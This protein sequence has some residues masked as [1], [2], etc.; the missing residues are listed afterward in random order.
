MSRISR[1]SAQTRP[2]RAEA[3]SEAARVASARAP[4]SDALRQSPHRSDRFEGTGR[5]F[6]P[7][8]IASTPKEIPS[9][10]QLVLREE[11]PIDVPSASGVVTLSKSRFIIVDDDM[12]IFHQKKEGADLLKSSKKHDML[13]DLEGLCRTPDGNGVFVLSEK[14]G[15]VYRLDFEG[16]GKDLD[17][18]KPVKQ[19]RLPK[20]SKKD[21]NKGWEGIDLLPGHFFDDGKARMVAVHEG[22]PK[23]VGVFALPDLK[24]GVIL[25]LPDDVADE[26]RDLSDIAVDPATGH[27]FVLSDESETIV[28]MRLVTERKSA[29]GAL[30]EKTTLE[31]VSVHDI[32]FRGVSKPEGLDFGPDG[33]LWVAMDGRSMLLAFDIER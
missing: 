20:L 17:L 14:S 2:L 33:T 11:R 29:P 25:K 12:G 31:T 8:P 23:R 5:G 9:A 6:V 16:E 13:R 32:S 26:L 4:A 21:P 27:V 19:G 1:R 10:K 18:G 28:E 7:R 30:V 3:A 24:D 22:L 15:E